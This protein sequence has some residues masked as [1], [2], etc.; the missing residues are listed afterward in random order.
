MTKHKALMKGVSLNRHNVL[1]QI[2][3]DIYFQRAS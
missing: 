2:K 1:V 3:S